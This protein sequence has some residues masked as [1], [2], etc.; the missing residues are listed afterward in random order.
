MRRRKRTSTNAER[1]ATNQQEVVT[2]SE[3]RLLREGARLDTRYENPT[4]V[5]ADQRD[6]P[7]QV[8]AEHGQFLHR[9]QGGVHPGE[10]RQRRAEGPARRRT[11]QNVLFRREGPQ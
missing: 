11:I 8:V 3:P 1:K 6:V 2:L 5:A 9:L 7:Q 4:L 10:G